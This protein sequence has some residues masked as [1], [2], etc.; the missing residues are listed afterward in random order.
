MMKSPVCALTEDDNRG[1]AVSDLLILG[2]T[3]L[4]HGF[5]CRMLDLDLLYIPQ[6][7]ISPSY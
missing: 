4:N 7:H 3:D 5:G 1:G 6:A 2:A